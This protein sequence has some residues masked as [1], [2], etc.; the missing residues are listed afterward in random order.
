MDLL[1]ALQSLSAA[2][3]SGYAVELETWAMG[4]SVEEGKEMSRVK[5]LNLMS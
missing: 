4:L 3:Q 2:A 5:L 1:Q